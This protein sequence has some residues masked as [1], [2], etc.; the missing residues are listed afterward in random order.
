MSQAGNRYERTIVEMRSEGCQEPDVLG[1]LESFAAKDRE[2]E[3]AYEALA[4]T[5]A[6]IAAGGEAGKKDIGQ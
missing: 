5:E 2:I 6:D 4:V 3:Q 1:L